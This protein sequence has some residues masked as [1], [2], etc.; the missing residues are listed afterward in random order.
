MKFSMW[1]QAVA[2]VFGLAM[3]GSA[4]AV[5]LDKGFSGSSPNYLD[6]QLP[7]TSAATRPEL[8]GSVIATDTQQFS[9]GG[10]NSD[11][12]TGQVESSVVRQGG[13]TLDFYWRVI[14]TGVS[15]ASTVSGVSA[16]RLG[17]FGYPFLV[18]ADWRSDGPGSTA[19]ATARLFNPANWPTGSISFVFAEPWVITTSQSRWFF[20]ST[21]AT[22]FAKTA[23][24]DLLSTGSQ[25]ISESFSTFAPAA[26]TVPE[27]GTLALLGLGLAGLGMAR[28]RKAN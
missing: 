22:N 24:F 13:G 23:I 28:R 20:L 16:L 25:T 7:G 17:D 9:F 4:G 19:A 26:A 27:P 8:A 12:V 1:V 14:V 15:A 11:F 5:S 2:A 21:N 6:T 10:Q 18:D 3:I